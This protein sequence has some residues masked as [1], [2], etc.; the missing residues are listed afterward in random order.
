M[1]TTTVTLA[2]KHRLWGGEGR[3]NPTLSVQQRG[4]SEREGRW[5][6]MRVV[7]EFALLGEVLVRLQHRR[8]LFDVLPRG[9]WGTVISQAHEQDVSHC[10]LHTTEG[11]Q[12]I[13][14]LEDCGG[15]SGQLSIKQV[16]LCCCPS[17]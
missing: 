2:H 3:L 8:P 12:S 7:T 5:D 1:T 15:V 4:N 17:S 14:G 10:G 9:G 13:E 6:L 16:R 11:I